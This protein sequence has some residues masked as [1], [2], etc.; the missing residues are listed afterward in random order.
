MLFNKKGI[1][2]APLGKKVGIAAPLAAAEGHV[3]PT[4]YNGSRMAA[5]Q[6]QRHGEGN[7]VYSIAVPVSLPATGWLPQCDNWQ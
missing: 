4:A 3:R 7:V 1:V 5:G 2:T 6:P